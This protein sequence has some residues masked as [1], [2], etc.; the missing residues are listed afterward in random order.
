MWVYDKPV[1]SG[2]MR[3]NSSEIDEVGNWCQE[4]LSGVPRKY[5]A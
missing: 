2:Y 3:L 4:S 5:E 1:V